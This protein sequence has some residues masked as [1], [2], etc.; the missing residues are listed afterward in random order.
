MYANNG[1]LNDQVRLLGYLMM[2]LAILTLNFRYLLPKSIIK[3]FKTIQ[4]LYHAFHIKL[5]VAFKLQPHFTL[6]P[7]HFHFILK[8]STRPTQGS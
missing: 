3:Y 5:L 7:N 6:K 8:T 2:K 1:C 4:A